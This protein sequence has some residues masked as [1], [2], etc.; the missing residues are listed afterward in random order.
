VVTAWVLGVRPEWEGLRVDPCLPPSWPGATMTR[1]W[2]GATYRITIERA[3]SLSATSPAQVTLDGV[4]VPDGV[5][6]PP[7]CP[8]E[9]HEVRVVIP[10]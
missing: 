4:P 9:V 7:G 6:P 2:R 3:G 1:P 5:L 8:G 10:A